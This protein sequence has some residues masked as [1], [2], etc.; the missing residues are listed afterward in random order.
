MRTIFK[1]SY[2]NSNVKKRNYKPQNPDFTEHSNFTIGNKKI[3]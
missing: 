1:E 3:E 2:M